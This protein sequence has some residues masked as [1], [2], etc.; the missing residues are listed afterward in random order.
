MEVARNVQ[1]TL[2]TKLITSLQCLKKNIDEVYIL[3]TD[4]H[5]SFLQVDRLDLVILLIILLYG[6]AS[7]SKK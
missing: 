3:R 4:K 7:C 1:G 5:E 2:N 6:L